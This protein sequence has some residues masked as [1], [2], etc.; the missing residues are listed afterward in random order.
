MKK[1]LVVLLVQS[2][3]YVNAQKNNIIYVEYK[4]V[5]A[6]NQVKADLEP[7][8]KKGL[9]MYREAVTNNEFH[10]YAN[11][12]IT[13]FAKKDKLITEKINALSQLI[14]NGVYYSNKKSKEKI[15][16]LE[17][18]G[19]L[20]N[21]TFAFDEYKWE[22]TAESKII[23]GYNC[24]K[25]IT[26]KETFS[27]SRNKVLVTNPVAWFSPEIPVNAGPF[28]LIGLPGLVLEATL[29][30]KTYYYATKIDLDYSGKASLKLEKPLKGKYVTEKELEKIQLGIY[31]DKN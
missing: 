20:F 21:I 18:L 2:F 6:E 27:K 23:Y 7:Q 13:V 29:N 4:T 15:K 28:G 16:H 17:M 25:A 31:E 9:E 14:G 26:H 1:F 11:D 19:E 3:L 24:Y 8:Y 12:S 10:L 30:G 5:T 22:I